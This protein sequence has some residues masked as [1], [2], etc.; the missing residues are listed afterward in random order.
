[1]P[2]TRCEVSSGC[3]GVAAEHASDVFFMMPRGAPPG[4][5]CLNCTLAASG[6]RVPLKFWK[7]PEVSY[8]QVME[9]SDFAS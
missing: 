2:D 6:E 3:I 8:F 9:Q 4:S 5:V 7:A 1:L